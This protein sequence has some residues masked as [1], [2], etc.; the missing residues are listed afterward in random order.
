[1]ATVN[2]YFDPVSVLLRCGHLV[3]I[4]NCIFTWSRQR[5][6]ESLLCV[7]H[8]PPFTLPCQWCLFWARSWWTRPC[9]RSETKRQNIDQ[10]RRGSACQP[11]EYPR[12]VLSFFYPGHACQASISQICQLWVSVIEQMFTFTLSW[13]SRG[14]CLSRVISSQ[15]LRISTCICGASAG[16]GIERELAWG[17]A[18][19]P[20]NGTRLRREL[21]CL[22]PGPRSGQWDTRPP[23]CLTQ[24]TGWIT[25]TGGLY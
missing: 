24:T 17:P 23:G 2:H 4:V 13:S 3:T 25:V 21:R 5:W 14:T 16:L 9:C 8:L 19:L 7:Y 15:W 10:L 11:E 20:T 12:W 18:H 1:M 6:V 22:Q